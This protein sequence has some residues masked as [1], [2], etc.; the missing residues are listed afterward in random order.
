V[1]FRNALRAAVPLM[2]RRHPHATV[3]KNGRTS[4]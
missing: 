1:G 4:A 2:E 3:I